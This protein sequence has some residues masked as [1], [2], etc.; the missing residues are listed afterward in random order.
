VQHVSSLDRAKARQRLP[1]RALTI[2]SLACV[3]VAALFALLFAQMR[4]GETRALRS[5]LD[6][7]AQEHT[8]L[9]QSKVDG[10]IQV[11]RAVASLREV[12]LV[13]S[14]EEFRVFVR[15]SLA[16][17]AEL[18][19][20]E[21]VPRVSRADRVAY[22]RAAHDDG[23]PSYVVREFD[24]ASL[25]PARSRGEYYPVHY[26][27][28]IDGNEQALGIDLASS[29]ERWA[30]LEQARDT[31]RAVA[32]PPLMLAQDGGGRYGVLLAL[33][34]YCRAASFASP[35][36]RARALMGFVVGVFHLD[37]LRE[38]VLAGLPDRSVE[39]TIRDR[40][41]G[42][43]VTPS[44]SALAQRPADRGQG[45]VLTAERGFDVGGRTWTVGFSTRAFQPLGR[46]REH[47]T[48]VI[49]LGICFTLLLGA[50][51]WRGLRRT[52]EVEERVR[53]RTLALTNEIAARNEAARA[54]E[55]KTAFLANMSHEIR[56]PL[57]AILGYAQILEV[58]P[59][60]P[61][62][63]RQPVQ[64]IATSGRH[65]LGVISDILDVSKIEAGRAEL[66]VTELD[67]GAILSEVGTLFA[68][69]CRRKGLAFRVE[70]LP[71]RGTRV[72]GDGGKLRQIL[73]NLLGNAVK[74]TDR[75]AVTLRVSRSPAD[76]QIF[77]VVDTGIGVPEAALRRILMPFHQE[78]VGRAAEGTGLG[79]AIARGYAELMDGT[80][81]VS[82]RVGEGS[83][84]AVDL[85]LPR[86][87]HRHEARGAVAVR[88]RL[89]PGTTVRALVADDVPENRDVLAR[90][91][92]ELGC[93]VS[94][95]RGGE[96]AVTQARGLFAGPGGGTGIVFC[97]V[98]MPDLDGWAVL[99]RLRGLPLGLHR[100]RIVAHSASAFAHERDAYL[101][102]GFDDFLAKP[103]DFE[104]VCACLAALP[105]I[106]L[107]T[108]EAATRGGDRAL[109]SRADL[110]VLPPELR[111]RILGAARVHNATALRACLRELV[112]LDVAGWPSV[113]SLDQALRAYDMHSI[114][115]LVSSAGGG[116]ASPAAG[117]A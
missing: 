95:A 22:E 66:H 24:G 9:L 53:E 37:R 71:A 82:S 36:E 11:L 46:F 33:P 114:V 113:D 100:T 45:R 47:S 99:A 75:G 54:N 60:L 91:L 102:G 87:G 109:G 105:G 51:L 70:G 27:E 65:L 44:S 21:W 28:P 84:F 76:R 80:I 40:A 58:D 81:S 42:R 107:E 35:A 94:V 77:E 62:G 93:E 29:P 101:K 41:S 38:P 26:V 17:H 32:T 12:E 110:A 57:N 73:I 10:S 97:D 16:D 103:I 6:T 19:A 106:A 85:P 74:F 98:R 116:E 88:R 56:T 89:A 92:T 7:L 61:A 23:Y 117:A 25:V 39:I 50:Y 63:C 14:R 68:D 69:Q 18:T 30:A 83:I 78:A 108:A 31:G 15:R 59:A 112:A 48:W 8:A 4:D 52:A 67:L 55:A 49:P 79:L 1:A 13:G 86:L 96:E 90:M 111:Q 64:T 5:H 72:R 3:G 43:L 2:S 34:V 115:T 104:H 20:L